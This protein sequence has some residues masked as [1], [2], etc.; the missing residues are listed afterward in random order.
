[1]LNFIRRIRDYI[2][3]LF[4]VLINIRTVIDDINYMTSHINTLEDIYK[5]KSDKDIIDFI[6]EWLTYMVDERNHDNLY[7]SYVA[8]YGY[9]K[10][11]ED[12]Y[13]LIKGERK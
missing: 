2:I 12:M 7:I 11:M 9:K 1:M 13:K 4:I 10:H 5:G 6:D 8:T 3:G